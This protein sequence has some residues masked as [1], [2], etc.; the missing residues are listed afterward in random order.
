GGRLTVGIGAGVSGFKAMGVK[1]ERP[2]LAIREAIQLMRRLWAHD[3]SVDFEGKTTSF[4]AATLDFSPIRKTILI[5]IAGRG[6]AVLQLAGE[7]ADGVMV[8]ALASEV[9]L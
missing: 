8:G 9:V 7:I 2:A 4:H 3:G 1:Q 6:P 5:W